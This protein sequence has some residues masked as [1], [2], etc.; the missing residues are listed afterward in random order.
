MRYRI[1]E[2]VL[3]S[4]QSEFYPQRATDICDVWYEFYGKEKDNDESQ[5]TWFSTLAAADI[6]IKNQKAND[7]VE[8]I[9]HER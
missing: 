1:V 7:V 5:Q 3:A 8:T 2:K 9:I 4:G 6:F